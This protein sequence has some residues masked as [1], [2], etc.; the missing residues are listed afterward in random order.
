MPRTVPCSLF[1]I[2]REDLKECTFFLVR[3]VPDLV[4]DEVL[5][6]GVFVYSPEEKYLDCLFTDDFRRIKSFHPQADLELLR[7]LQQHFEEEINRRSDDWEGYIRSLQEYSNLIQVTEPRPCRLRDPMTE[8]QDLFARYVG[9]R[10]SG[11][12]PENTRLRIKQ[13]LTAAFVRVGVWERLDK[14]ISVSTWTHPGDAFTFDYGYTSLQADSKPNGHLK[15]VHALSQKRDAKLAKE[16]VYT[17][18]HVRRK[19]SAQLAAVVEDVPES[20]LD[21]IYTRGILQEGGIS[22]QLLSGLEDYA[23]SVRRELLGLMD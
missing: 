4:R 12:P 8:I 20:D 1:Q 18:D 10:I 7:E 13:K 15:F 14:R 22:I 3:Y 21:A 19:E 23:Q 11:S 16:L 6:I 2:G 5:N 9:G 17:L